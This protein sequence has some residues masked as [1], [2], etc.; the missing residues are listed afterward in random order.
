MLIVT[1][2]ELLHLRNLLVAKK[3]E[4]RG[5]FLTKEL[6]IGLRFWGVWGGLSRGYPNIK[7]LM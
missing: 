3:K 5:V 1:L 4:K 2:P 6:K 7:Y